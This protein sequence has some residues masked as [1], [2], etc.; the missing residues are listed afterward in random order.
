MSPGSLAIR[1]E[2]CGEDMREGR[3]GTKHG[4]KTRWKNG[5]VLPD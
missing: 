3:K 4:G 1:G 5:P 2:R